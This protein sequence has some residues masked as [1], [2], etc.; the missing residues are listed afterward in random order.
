MQHPDEVLSAAFNTDGSLVLTGCKDGTARLWDA[1][2]GL[3]LGPDLRHDAP[4]SVVA[5]SPD[6]K[7]M[8]TGAGKEVRLWKGTQPMEGSP[9][10]IKLWAEVLTGLEVTANGELKQVDVERWYAKRIELLQKKDAP[11]LP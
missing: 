11:P 4:V 9:E 8:L 6:G 2:N 5:F 3:Q 10:T 1:E 7:T